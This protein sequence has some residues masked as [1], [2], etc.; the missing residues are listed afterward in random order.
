MMWSQCETHLSPLPLVTR[1]KLPLYP[2]DTDLVSTRVRASIERNVSYRQ[3]ESRVCCLI[4]RCIHST[5]HEHLMR[6]EL[7][8]TVASS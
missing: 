8:G 7:V 1:E 5:Y 4:D 3:R 2:M 6:E